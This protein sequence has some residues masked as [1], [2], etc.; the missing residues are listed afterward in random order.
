MTDPLLF[1]VVDDCPGRYDEFFRL[2]DAAGH[3]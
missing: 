3:R 2:C 1:L